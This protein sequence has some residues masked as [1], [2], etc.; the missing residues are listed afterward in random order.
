MERDLALK[1]LMSEKLQEM[2]DAHLNQKLEMEKQREKIMSDYDMRINSRE[3]QIQH[4]I[5]DLDNERTKVCK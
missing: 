5:T 2:E 4:L 1:Q 3:K